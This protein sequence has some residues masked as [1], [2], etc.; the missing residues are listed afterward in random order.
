MYYNLK[1]IET[2]TSVKTISLQKTFE[3]GKNLNKKVF[4]V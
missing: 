1:H 4:T 2:V 3:K